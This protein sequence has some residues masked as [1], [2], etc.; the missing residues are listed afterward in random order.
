MS[1]VGGV[2]HLDLN[3]TQAVTWSMRSPVPGLQ[4][5]G[6]ISREGLHSK[7]SK[8]GAIQEKQVEPCQTQKEFERKALRGLQVSPYFKISQ[9]P[10]PPPNQAAVIVCYCRCKA[11]L[12]PTTAF[13]PSLQSNAKLTSIWHL[14][15]VPLSMKACTFIEQWCCTWSKLGHCPPTRSSVI[16]QPWWSHHC[17][18]GK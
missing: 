18:P 7:Q 5:Y 1:I 12:D 16:F 2:A 10:P 14:T 8:W 6:L 17:S 3:R 15:Q 11:S 13:L 4:V 9:P